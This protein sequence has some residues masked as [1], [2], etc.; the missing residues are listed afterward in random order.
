MA[1][2]RLSQKVPGDIVKL[3]E[4]GYLKE[5]IVVQHDYPTG[6]NGLTLLIRKYLHTRSKSDIPNNNVWIDYANGPIDT[7]LNNTFISMLD[8]EVQASIPQISIEYAKLVNNG[9][10]LEV[11]TI[12]RKAFLLSYFELY[13]TV[14]AGFV[15]EG[16]KLD[17]FAKEGNAQYRAYSEYPE[18]FD[19]WWIRS[20]YMYNGYTSG[21]YFWD[22]GQH[23]INWPAG[24]AQFDEK[25]FPYI[26][27]SLTLPSTMAV[28]DSGEVVPNIAPTNPA[29]ISIPIEIRGGESATISWGASSDF[30]NNLA[31]YRLERSV[32]DGTY[33]QVLQTTA[34]SSIQPITRGWNTVAFRVK[35]YDT[36][37]YESGYTVSPTRV[38]INNDPP[39]IS[40]IDMNMGVHAVPFTYAYTVDDRQKD[41]LRISETIVSEAGNIN[42]CVIENVNAG[43][44]HVVNLEKQWLQ[45]KGNAKLIIEVTDPSG[46][47]AVRTISFTRSVPR[48]AASRKFTTKEPVKKCIVTVVGSGIAYD[49]SVI[50]EVCNNPY[51]NEPV[52]E[53]IPNKLNKE[54]HTFANK[55]VN[56]P[57]FAYRFS[58]TK[59]EKEIYITGI[60]IKY[61]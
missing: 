34:L 7:W 38:V 15:R 47:K 13:G 9:R 46:A 19:F 48:I 8:P 61:A 50:F 4:N 23:M 31:G 14:P 57:G 42:V 53:N 5:Y 32:N 11:G 54:A 22:D 33:E 12:A 6:G 41:K 25:T 59:N 30:D 29:G 37:N 55:T 2:V 1:T 51:D 49:T 10:Q 45:I 35:A 56:N 36:Y 58:I 26:R 44:S 17:Y 21:R 43:S 28:L 52:W 20:F 40:G 3:K 18:K 39:T 16:I 60:N 24:D 27:P